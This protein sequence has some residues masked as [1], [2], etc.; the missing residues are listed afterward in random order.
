M[1]YRIK[2]FPKKILQTIFQPKKRLDKKNFYTK[3][4]PQI[5]FRTNFF[6]PKNNIRQKYFS[7]RKLFGQKNLKNILEEKF[8][9]KHYEKKLLEKN[10]DK[11]NYDK[12][13]IDQNI[14]RQKNSTKKN[15]ATSM[16]K[17]LLTKNVSTKKLREQ[18]NCID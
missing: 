8:L 6:L 11:K 12:K 5:E 4:F 14:F 1:N 7:S 13:K 16:K 9:P 2:N 10:L 3:M 15:I 17:I 18:R